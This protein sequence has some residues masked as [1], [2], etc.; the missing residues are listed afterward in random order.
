MAKPLYEFQDRMWQDLTGNLFS[1]LNLSVMTGYSSI[2]V[3]SVRI[4]GNRK[5]GIQ[6]TTLIGACLE[7]VT[8]NAS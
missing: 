5:S 4:A 7:L 8:E 1:F 2:R 6:E 3:P